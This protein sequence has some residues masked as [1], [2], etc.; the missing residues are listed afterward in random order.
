MVMYWYVTFI[1]NMKNTIKFHQGQH[2]DITMI[3]RINYIEPIVT[4]IFCASDSK[5]LIDI[6]DDDWKQ[7]MTIMTMR[8]LTRINI[9]INNVINRKKY[10]RSMYDVILPNDVTIKTVCK[11]LRILDRSKILKNTTAYFF[12][13]N[14][15]DQKIIS[16]YS[17]A[18]STFK[19]LYGTFRVSERD[20][21]FI[22]LTDDCALDDLEFI[23]NEFVTVK[24]QMNLMKQKGD[25]KRL[26]FYNDLI[27]N[28]PHIMFQLP[29][30]EDYENYI[31]KIYS[32][33]D[34]NEVQQFYKN[35]IYR[36]QQYSTESY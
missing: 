30:K 6:L 29:T 5:S 26:K 12:D 10:G 2:V 7:T 16:T 19:E 25:T 24:I 8:N 14:K 27:S 1:Y 11:K 23:Q 28:R 31:T 15:M 34:E 20:D 21:F 9:T 22:P 35:E 36:L 3:Y 17:I 13:P 18:Y 32:L 4:N 33:I